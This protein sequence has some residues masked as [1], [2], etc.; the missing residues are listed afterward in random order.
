M[1][2][3]QRVFRVVAYQTTRLTLD[4]TAAS[5]EEAVAKANGVEVVGWVEDI[6]SYTFEIVTCQRV[7]EEE[8]AEEAEGE[9]EPTCGG[10]GKQTR[11]NYVRC[12]ECQKVLCD[13][14]DVRTGDEA[15]LCREH[16]RNEQEAT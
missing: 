15:P 16:R 7:E 3:K 8:D 13:A 12:V 14:C 6:D 10:C 1:S 4:V 5:A 11:G 9:E 2:T